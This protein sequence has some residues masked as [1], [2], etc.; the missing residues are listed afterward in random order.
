MHRVRDVPA[1]TIGGKIDAF[2]KAQIHQQMLARGIVA[3][4]FALLDNA[5]AVRVRHRFAPAFGKFFADGRDALAA[6]SQAPMRAGADARI[7]AIAPIEKIVAA[8]CARARMIG[9]LISGKAGSFA[10]IPA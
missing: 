10:S 5:M 1:R 2:G 9:D 4:N 6:R 8:L 3:R 7:I